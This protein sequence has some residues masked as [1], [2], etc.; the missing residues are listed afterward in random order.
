LIYCKND[1]GVDLDETEY[2]K[3]LSRAKTYCEKSG[4]AFYEAGKNTSRVILVDKCE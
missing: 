4:T 2:I 3:L 1:E